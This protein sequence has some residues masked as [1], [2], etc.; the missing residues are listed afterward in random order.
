MHK[1]TLKALVEVWL[2]LSL[3]IVATDISLYDNQGAV[4]VRGQSE[5]GVAGGTRKKASC[6]YPLDENASRDL[7]FRGTCWDWARGS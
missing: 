1:F 3:E 7:Q 5:S 6:S 2:P 4:R